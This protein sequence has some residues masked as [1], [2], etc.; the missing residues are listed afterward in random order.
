MIGYAIKIG[1]Q[2]VMYDLRH[3]FATRMGRSRGRPGGAEGD[4]GTFRHPSDDAV[5]SRKAHQDKAMEV[6]DRLN[7]QARGRQMLQ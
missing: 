1:V 3:T 4:P 6:Y 2:F 7:E 5:R